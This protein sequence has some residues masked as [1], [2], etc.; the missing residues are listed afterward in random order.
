MSEP[1]VERVQ[2]VK[3]AVVKRGLHMN[4]CMREAEVAAFEKRHQIVLPQD[5]RLFLLE[6]GNGGEGPPAYGLL[7]L[8]EV[9][10]DYD[11]SAGEVQDAINKPFPLSQA[12]VWEGERADNAELREA[13]DQGILVLGT[14]GCALYW[15]LI[16][17]GGERGQIWCKADVGIQPC[18]PRRDFLSWYEYWLEGGKDWWAEYQP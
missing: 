7:R 14:D 16:V 5:Y 13:L 1:L 15:L 8:G 6:V 11:R 18:A 3:L 4:P 17:T 12:W 10:E 9:P 2:R